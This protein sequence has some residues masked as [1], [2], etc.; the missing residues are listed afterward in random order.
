MQ[1]VSLLQSC[2]QRAVQPVLEVDVALPLHGMG[3]QVAVK[4]GVLVEQLVERQLLAVVISSSRRT[5]RGG[6][7]DQS[8]ADRA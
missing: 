6:T 2:P 3:E 1:G 4:R 5:A 8:R 7:L